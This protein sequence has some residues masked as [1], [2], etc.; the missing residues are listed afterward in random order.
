MLNYS[1]AD[2]SLIEVRHG[3]V[4]NHAEFCRSHSGWVVFPKPP[5]TWAFLGR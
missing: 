5:R 2:L 3:P 4:A 1:V